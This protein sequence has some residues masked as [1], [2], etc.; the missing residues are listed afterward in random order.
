MIVHEK[1]DNTSPQTASKHLPIE[2]PCHAITCASCVTAN[3]AFSTP[4]EARKASM[5]FTYSTPSMVRDTLSLV[6]AVWRQVGWVRCGVW[7]GGTQHRLWRP[8]EKS[9]RAARAPARQRASQE[10]A[11]KQPAQQYAS[12]A[13]WPATCASWQ[14]HPTTYLVGHW[15]R[16]LLQAVSVGNAVHLLSSGRGGG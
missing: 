14:P 16:G 2:P 5:T 15:D 7:V 8:C 12:A 10:A 13:A 4:Y 11:Q 9:S 6:M 3:R 1:G